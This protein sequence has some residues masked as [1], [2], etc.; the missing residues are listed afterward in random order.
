MTRFDTIHERDGQTDRLCPS[1]CLSRQTDT[2][3]RHRPR[4]CIP[5]RS[6][7]GGR[8]DTTYII[9]LA[10]GVLLIGTVPILI[11]LNDREH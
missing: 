2:A 10:T 1:V 11:T 9:L 5:P 7:N 3:R 6:K 8:Y 4:L